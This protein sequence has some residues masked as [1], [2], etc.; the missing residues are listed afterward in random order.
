M[1]FNKDNPQWQLSQEQ[2]LNEEE[3]SRIIYEYDQLCRSMF[4]VD[5]RDINSKF[6]GVKELGTVEQQEAKRKRAIIG[7]VC[8]IVVFASLVI[9][10]I[11]KQILI[12]G[13]IFCAVFLFAGIST[14]VTGRGE[15]VESTSKA[16]LNRIIGAGISLGS[17]LILLLIIFR[18]RFEEA[19]F[20]ILIGVLAFGIS[21]LALLVLSILK[22]LSGKFIYTEE[23][24]ATCAGYV[25][26]VER[27]SGESNHIRHTFI[28]LSP[29]FKYSYG[30]VNYES[31][32]DEFVV[33]G[34]S[35]IS[36]GQTVPVRIDPRHPENIMSPA[37][38]NKGALI[39]KLFLAVV[40]ITV[41]TGMGIYVANGSAKGMTVETSWNPAI[42]RLNGVTESTKKQITDEM[43]KTQFVDKYNI[44]G[45]WYYETVVIASKEDSAEGQS[46]KFTDE[47]FGGILYTGSNV[48]EPGASLIV[49]YT[50]D[51]EYVQHGTKYKRVFTTADPDT[52]EYVGSHKAYIAG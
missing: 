43:V 47:T 11:F 40:C 34:D 31:V 18:N 37:M 23:I 26:C 21:G 13:Y 29:L 24:N 27:E 36:L 8:G 22:P 51:E 7:I 38:K 1:Y 50:V 41:A 44:T 46:V 4:S 20:F 33:N 30:G 10:L 52:F 32:W 6:Y 35:D 14:I 25:R 5:V 12:F 2:Y 48:L 28:M 17:I 16:Y 19:E 15:V 9:S 3:R 45:E 39:L 42:E 49:F